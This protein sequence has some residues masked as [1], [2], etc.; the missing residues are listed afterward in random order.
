LYFFSPFVFFIALFGR[1]ATREFKNQKTKKRKSF[2]E[3][4]NKIHLPSALITKK[5][6]FFSSVLPPSRPPAPP[7][8]MSL[9]GFEIAYSLLAVSVS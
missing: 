9:L 4:G 2:F 8:S 1:F 7:A 5:C 6:G 3:A